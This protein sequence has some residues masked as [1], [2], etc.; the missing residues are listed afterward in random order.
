METTQETTV[1][2]TL[3]VLDPNFDSP[4][5]AAIRSLILTARGAKREDTSLCLEGDE[6]AAFRNL[7][8]AVAKYGD[9]RAAEA[10]ADF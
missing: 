2:K 4:L 9:E 1:Q 6:I 8:L 5:H 3:L 7:T 10:F